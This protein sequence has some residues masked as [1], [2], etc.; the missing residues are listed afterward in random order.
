MRAKSWS[1]G[2]TTFLCVGVAGY[3]VW[4]YGSGVQRVPVHPD[5]VA[6]FD[7]HR[8]LITL[9]AVGASIALLLG[10]LQFIDSWRARSPRLHRITGYLYLLPGVGMGGVTGVLLARYSFGGLVS[11]LGFGMLGCLWLFTGFMALASARKRRFEEH[12]RWMTRNFALCL[13]A[14]TLRIYLPLSMIAGLPFEQAYPAIAWLCWVPNL[15]VAEWYWKRL[16]P[17]PGKA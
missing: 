6:V 9:H 2:L 4:A 12:R 13:A 10:P 3:A 16:H 15:I 11:H 1:F 14:V 17:L 5:M 8:T 7:A